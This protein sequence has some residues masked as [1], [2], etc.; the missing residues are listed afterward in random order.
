MWVAESQ[1]DVLGN[2]F[3]VRSDTEQVAEWVRGL[4]APFAAPAPAGVRAKNMFALASRR[5]DDARHYAYRDCRRIGRSESWTKVLDLFLGE[6]NRRAVEDMS[7]FGVHAGV[8]ASDKRT[9]ALPGASGAGKT[10]LVGAC[11]QA[12]FRYVSDEALCLDYSTGTVISYPKPLSLSTW[13]LQ[14]LGV[15]Q[16]NLD[17]NSDGSK[18]P[19]HP[20]AIGGVIAG[21][22]PELSDLVI[23]ERGPGPATLRELPRSQVVRALLAYSFNHY[24][25]PSDAFHLVTELAR[26]THAWVLTYEDQREAADLL[27]TT[28]F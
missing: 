22:P 13:S 26:H 16:P 5:P 3:G 1:Y 27:R 17:S 8:V 10:T 18:T 24:K 12:G 21:V 11:L 23:F 15:E 2:R 20:N 4:L 25:Q 19:L 14:V 6:L 9:I 7:H 28:F